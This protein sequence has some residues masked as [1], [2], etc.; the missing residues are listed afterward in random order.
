MKSRLMILAFFVAVLS[1]T[2]GSSLLA[3]SAMIATPEQVKAMGGVIGPAVTA[4]LQKVWDKAGYAKVKTMEY[5]GGAGMNAAVGQQYSINDDWPRFQVDNY[6]RTTDFETGQTCEEYTKQQ[7]P[8]YPPHGGGGTPLIGVHTW[9]S[10]VAGDYAWDVVDGKTIPQVNGHLYGTSEADFRKLDGIICTPIGFLKAAMAPGANPSMLSIPANQSP[11]HNAGNIR[12]IA[13]QALGKYRVVGMIDDRDTVEA[14]FTWVGNPFIGELDAQYR[15]GRFKDFNGV[16]YPTNLHIHAGD[17]GISNSHNSQDYYTADVK[18]NV[19]VAPVT[20]PDAVKNAKSNVT[21]VESKKLADGV[22]L[23]CGSDLNSVAIE[24][25]DYVA[26]FEA[27]MNEQRSI[28]VIAEINKL[29]PNKPI[30]YVINSSHHWDHAGGLRTYYTQGATVITNE[31]NQAYFSKVLFN[32]VPDRNLMPDRYAYYYVTPGAARAFSN[33]QYVN[34]GTM[35]LTDGD[36]SIE[37]YTV[38]GPAMFS[39]EEKDIRM[40]TSTRDVKQFDAVGMLV[41]YLPKAKILINAELYKPEKPG[42][43]PPPVDNNMNMLL[44]AVKSHHMNVTQVVSID[45]PYVATGEQLEKT[46]G[47][48]KPVVEE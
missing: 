13:I 11:V 47:P 5:H 29:I 16:Q 31:S 19:P 9:K 42:D 7:G 48:V 33:V 34:H 41:A 4:V 38:S 32:Y 23:I 28:A 10:C 35:T 18:W 24:F 2:A 21:N 3:Q 22:W 20:V 27:P 46:V 15:Y 25:K 40:S 26:V 8:N 45:S 6:V 36:Q 12:A 14:V 37:L 1:F 30:K 44:G 17:G 39:T 43:A